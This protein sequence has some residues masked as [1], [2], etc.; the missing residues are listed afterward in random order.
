M[1]EVIIVSLHLK[2]ALYI[3]IILPFK[4]KKKKKHLK[5]R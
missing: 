5:Y 4:K 3:I 2:G 1:I